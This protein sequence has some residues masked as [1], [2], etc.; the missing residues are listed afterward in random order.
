M[1][2][3]PHC[4]GTVV[5]AKAIEHLLDGTGEGSYKDEHPWL[6]ARDLLAASTE[7]ELGLPILFATGEPLVF[8]HWSFLKRIQVVELH[9]GQWETICDFTRLQSVNPIF[10]ELDSVFLKPTNEQLQRE[11]REGLRQH[12]FSL[13]ESHVRPY[14]ICETPAYIAGD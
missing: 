6:V 7:A 12:R 13:D 5:A 8:T 2:V 9:R 14:A 1:E 10:S 11:R 3:S 4:I